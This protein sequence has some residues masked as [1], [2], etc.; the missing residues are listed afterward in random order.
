MK[1]LWRTLPRAVRWLLVTTLIL[2]LAAGGV[3]AYKALTAEVTLTV[4]ECL[5]FVGDSTFTV[6]LYPLESETVEITVAN[7]SS[8][9][10]DVDLL[11]TII[12]DPGA[13]GL[14]VTI[15]KTIT[16]PATGQEVVSVV[17][18]A[19]KSAEP[20]AYAITIDFER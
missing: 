14:T 8:F 11:S 19:G 7:A 15:P 9:D 12:P 16:V 5:S 10:L 3:Y 2:I 6:S 13:K 17:I 18:E 20:I 1:R 4:E